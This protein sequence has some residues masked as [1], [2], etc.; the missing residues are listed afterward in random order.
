[1]R[2]CAGF[3]LIELVIILAILAVLAAILFPAI[4]QA[5][6]AKTGNSISDLRQQETAIKLYALDHGNDVAQDD[7]ATSHR[8]RTA[9]SLSAL[10][11]G[12]IQDDSNWQ[13]LNGG[14]QD[15]RSGLV[16]SRT[17]D[18]STGYY[19]RVYMRPPGDLRLPGAYEYCRD[20]AEGTC[21]DQPD[22]LCRGWRLPSKDEA[23]LAASHQIKNYA[24]MRYPDGWNRAADPSWLETKGKD[25]GNYLCYRI[26]LGTGTW[27]ISLWKDKSG[28]LYS[29]GDTICVRK[30]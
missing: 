6:V 10:A 27:G 11:T 2:K 20:L 3:T 15:M 19:N 16:W 12:C 8:F 17:S 4:A 13:S 23:V 14:C 1:M 9:N 30:P 28:N 21:L 26:V 25:K 18:E 29:V 7:V 24:P 22:G 5:R